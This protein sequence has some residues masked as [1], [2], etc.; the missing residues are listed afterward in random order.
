MDPSVWS[1][2]SELNVKVNGADVLEKPDAVFCILNEKA[3]INIPAP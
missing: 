1:F 3:V 2:L